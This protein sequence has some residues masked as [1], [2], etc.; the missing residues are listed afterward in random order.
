MA[1][2]KF[3]YVIY[4]RTTREKLWHALTKPDSTRQYWCEMTQE[5]EW[6]PGA[7]WRILDPNGRTFDSGQV[8]E[9]TPEHHLVLKWRHEVDAKMKAEGYSRLSYDLEDKADT[10]KLTVQH[11]MGVGDSKLIKAVSEGWPAILSSLKSLLETERPL[12]VTRHSEEK[13]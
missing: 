4:I 13:I 3:T 12:E 5:S 6:K 9:I 2:S 11:T 10:V 8:V 7:S 1:D